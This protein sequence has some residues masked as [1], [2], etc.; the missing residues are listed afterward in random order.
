MEFIDLVDRILALI[1]PL[2]SMEGAPKQLGIPDEKFPDN[3]EPFPRTQKGS[4][5]AK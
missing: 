3:H 5:K 1:V 2:G 4:R